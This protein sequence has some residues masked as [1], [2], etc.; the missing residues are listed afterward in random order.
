MKALTEC[1]LI[2]AR[3]LFGPLKV[4]FWLVARVVLHDRSRGRVAD[5]QH[6]KVA[7]RSLLEFFRSKRLPAFSNR[8]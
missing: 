7:E 5:G 6:P 2:G 4:G 3:R 1:E 8:R